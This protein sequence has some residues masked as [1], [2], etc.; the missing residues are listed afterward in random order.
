MADLA[1]AKVT[2]FGKLTDSGSTIR[3]T[4][5]NPEGKLSRSPSLKEITQFSQNRKWNI[6]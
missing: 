5:Q 6:S 1:L 3:P 4:I 2:V